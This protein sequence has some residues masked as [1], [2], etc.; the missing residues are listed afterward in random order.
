MLL[1]YHRWNN[2]EAQCV[3]K[4]VVFKSKMLVKQGDL[5]SQMKQGELYLK[6][7]NAGPSW[8]HDLGKK[9][10]NL[11]KHWTSS[12]TWNWKPM[13]LFHT[14][15][16][17]YLQ[18]YSPQS[19]NSLLIYSYEMMYFGHLCKKGIAVR[20]YC[21]CSLGLQ[22]EKEKGSRRPVERHQNLVY[23]YAGQKLYP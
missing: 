12:H 6:I 16:A 7:W 23:I 17:D 15:F 3:C 10:L 1:K 11:G 5:K 18:I 2:A 20:S 9:F 13:F 4:V 22:Q 19:H 21:Y 8:K 14:F